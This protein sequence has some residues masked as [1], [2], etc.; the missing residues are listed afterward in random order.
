MSKEKKVIIKS[1]KLRKQVRKIFDKVDK[2]NKTDLLRKLAKLNK[3][4]IG[5]IRKYLKTKKIEIDV[6]RKSVEKSRKETGK[7]DIKNVDEISFDIVKALR[8]IRKKVSTRREDELKFARDIL[9]VIEPVINNYDNALRNGVFSTSLSAV[10][11]YRAFDNLKTAHACIE[12][13][14]SHDNYKF[15]EEYTRILDLGKVVNPKKMKFDLKYSEANYIPVSGSLKKKD[16][17]RKR[18]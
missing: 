3:C 2:I 14:L 9:L 13:M 12:K 15:L 11:I 5:T 7:P 17:K 16:E 4:S 10:Y 8:N 6:K 1:K 18:K